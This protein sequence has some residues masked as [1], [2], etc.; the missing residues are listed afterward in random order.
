[1]HGIYFCNYNWCWKP[2][3]I[4]MT[5]AQASGDC[6]SAVDGSGFVRAINVSKILLGRAYPY[7]HAAIFM[8]L[9]YS[10]AYAQL[11]PAIL[12]AVATQGLVYMKHGIKHSD[13][14]H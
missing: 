4:R 3:T 1:M 9:F 8:G 2:E 12:F 13:Q 14:L 6:G 5:P 7:F 11:V 10:V